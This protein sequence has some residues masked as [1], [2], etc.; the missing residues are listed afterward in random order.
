MRLT[1][2]GAR[3]ARSPR[4]SRPGLRTSRTVRSSATPRTVL[5]G[6]DRPSSGA[7]R[8]PR[9]R[10]V[11]NGVMSRWQRSMEI[12]KASWAVLKSD[13][14]LVWLP[15]LSFLAT[16]VV[17][18]V[19]AGLVFLPRTHTAA[20]HEQVGAVGYV[21]AAIGYFAIAFVGVY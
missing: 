21:L 10:L 19:F 5:R 4:A 7:R 8:Q 12:A 20:G 15:V 14:Q 9:P 18:G 11:D 2:P 6:P 13:K 17:V 3:T 16:L 1:R